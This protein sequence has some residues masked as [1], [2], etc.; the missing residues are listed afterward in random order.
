MYLCE[1]VLFFTLCNQNNILQD[2]ESKAQEGIQL[3]SINREKKEIRKHGKLTQ[4][5]TAVRRTQG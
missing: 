5:L 3:P 1:H 2:I 4:R